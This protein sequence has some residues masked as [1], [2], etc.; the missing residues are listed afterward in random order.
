MHAEDPAEWPHANQTDD[1]GYSTRAL[2]WWV[3]VSLVV[4]AAIVVLGVWKAIDLVR[5]WL[6]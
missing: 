1:D 5:Q 4:S 3:G 6:M 2:V